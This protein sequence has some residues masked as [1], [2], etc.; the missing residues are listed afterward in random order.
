MQPNKSTSFLTPLCGLS[1]EVVFNYYYK[2]TFCG[3][4]QYSKSAE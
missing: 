2:Q 1:K 3:S 4:T